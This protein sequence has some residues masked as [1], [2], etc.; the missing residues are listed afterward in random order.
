MNTHL[1]DGLYAVVQPNW[2]AGFIVQ[3]GRIDPSLCAPILRKRISHW[4][5]MARFVCS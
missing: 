4:V 5:M 2:V 1:S 3:S